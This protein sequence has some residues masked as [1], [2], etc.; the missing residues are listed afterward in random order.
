MDVY[1]ACIICT[2][3][4]SWQKC[5]SSALERDLHLSPRPTP[6]TQKVF[7]IRTKGKYVPR[8]PLTSPSATRDRET[9]SLW[10]SLSLPPQGQTC[11]RVGTPNVI[12][13]QRVSES[14]F[15]F[16]QINNSFVTGGTSVCLE[17]IISFP[18]AWAR[19]EAQRDTLF[20][21]IKIFCDKKGKKISLWTTFLGWSCGQSPMESGWGLHR[22]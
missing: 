21:C 12:P 5:I 13:R 17:I 1:L 16:L 9:S 15:D 19:L 14:K 11:Q 7:D 2:G 3:S 4:F 6:L 8:N 22:H 20:F 10:I 18:N